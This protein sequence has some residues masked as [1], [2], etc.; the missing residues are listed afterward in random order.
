MDQLIQFVNDKLISGSTAYELQELH[1]ILAGN[2]EE[3]GLVAEALRIVKHKQETGG[4]E[5]SKGEKAI[6][7][8]WVRTI[9]LDELSKEMI[10]AKAL[11]NA[12]ELEQLVEVSS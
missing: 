6:I 3:E 2:I 10:I 1:R 8:G 4:G 9:S 5:I 11:T 12:P 7:E